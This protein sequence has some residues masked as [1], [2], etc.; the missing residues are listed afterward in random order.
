MKRTYLLFTC[1]LAALMM[2][3]AQ[4]SQEQAKHAAEQF[5]E[6]KVGKIASISE[7]KALPFVHTWSF[8]DN[9]D[10]EVMAYAVNPGQ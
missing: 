6:Q 3:A 4:F 8:A 7:I 9:N 1:A 10:C 2:T 5:V